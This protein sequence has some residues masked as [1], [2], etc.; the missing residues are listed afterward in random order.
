[1]YCVASM[2]D[3]LTL[4]FSILPSVSYPDGQGLLL[5]LRLGIPI[6]ETTEVR[7]KKLAPP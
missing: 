5:L 1:M 6:L 2:E 7:Y 4:S 3:T